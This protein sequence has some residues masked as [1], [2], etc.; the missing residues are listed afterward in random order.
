MHPGA[1]AGVGSAD[2]RS[3][4]GLVIDLHELDRC[5]ADLD[6][7]DGHATAGTIRLDDD[8]MTFEGGREVINLE[9]HMWHRFD[10]VRIRSAVPVPLPLNTERII[11]VIADSHL[12]VR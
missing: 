8:V 2:Y 7:G 1:R 4:R 10:Q 12:Q 3:G 9:C 11:Q 5:A 6:E